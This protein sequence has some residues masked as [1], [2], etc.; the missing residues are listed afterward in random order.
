MRL[1]GGKRRQEGEPPP[2]DPRAAA[3][4]LGAM[5]ESAVTDREGRIR[6][7]DLL[8]AAAAVCGE[9]CIAAAGEFDPE[10]HDFVPGSAVL[11][12]RVNEILC[13]NAGDW[14]STG[15]SVFG[16]IYR[17]VLAHGYGE[18]DFP[19]LADVFRMY[20]STM[21]G[22]DAERW[23]YVGLSVA[24]ENWPRV[25]PLRYAYE[26]RAP[27]R[28][29]LGRLA[30][31]AASWPAAFAH[32][33]AGELGRV[34]QAIDPGVAL[35]IVLETTNGMAKMAPMTDRHFLESATGEA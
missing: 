16:V 5:L 4:L 23:G 9:A 20:V 11:S 7:E 6:V 18:A 25:A 29:I 21:G 24:E 2:S 19:P 10:D 8:T 17:G 33:I 1:F 35:R 22:G 26:L 34:R 3:G 28:E 27:T 15:D 31:P 30:L 13:A 14:S 12:D 32:A